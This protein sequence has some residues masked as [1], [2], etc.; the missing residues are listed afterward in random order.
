VEKAHILAIYKELKGNK[1]LT[2][3]EPG[4]GLNTL[5]RKPASYGV[6]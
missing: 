5:R 1:S 4:I 3:R 2:A 6:D